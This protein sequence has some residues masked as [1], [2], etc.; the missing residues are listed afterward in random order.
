M[1]NFVIVEP[2]CVAT[3]MTC[4]NLSSRVLSTMNDTIITMLDQTPKSLDIQN[5]ENESN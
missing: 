2:L 5:G 3:C 1:I 4:N